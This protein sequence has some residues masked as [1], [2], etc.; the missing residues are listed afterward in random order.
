MG[1]IKSIG[2]GVVLLAVIVGLA[3]WAQRSGEKPEPIESPSP[4]ASV[5]TS[6][7]NMHEVTITTNLGDIVFQTY[8][9][10]APKAV[11]NFI[12]LAN[13]GFYNGVTFHRVIEGFMIQGGDPKGD[14][15]GGPGYTFEDELDP[16]TESARK[17]YARGTVAMANAGP[18]TNGS[19]FFIM[20]QD[21]P[22]PHNYTIFG[23]VVRG[24][25][26]VD[27]IATTKTGA[28]DK[29][30]TP[31]IMKKVTVVEVQK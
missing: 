21:Y 6:T 17:G 11:S 27:V 23:H 9:G 4:T 31:V 29:P 7:N 2:V 13:K 16:N 15:T 8:D 1:V 19:Q 28:N 20:H 5:S 12:D 10:D 22:L 26:V 24:Q 18:N 3:V 30:V 14:G 25:D